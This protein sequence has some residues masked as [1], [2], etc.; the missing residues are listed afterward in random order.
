MADR[1]NHRL[2]VEIERQISMWDGTIHGQTIKNMYEN[3]SDYESICDVMQID[4]ADY[5]EE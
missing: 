2:N 5:E 3:G 1:S 4:Y